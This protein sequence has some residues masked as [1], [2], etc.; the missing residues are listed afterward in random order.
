MSL[1]FIMKTTLRWRGGSRFSQNWN[2]AKIPSYIPHLPPPTQEYLNLF[3]E[4]MSYFGLKRI[5]KI[6]VLGVCPDFWITSTPPKMNISNSQYSLLEQLPGDIPKGWELVIRGW[7]WL[8]HGAWA[9][10]RSLPWDDHPYVKLGSF[11]PPYGLGRHALGA[12]PRSLPW[13]WPSLG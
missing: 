11:S 13:G 9:F 4:M 2:M 6:M 7:W 10:P 8:G 1:Q 12:F 5:K 3:E